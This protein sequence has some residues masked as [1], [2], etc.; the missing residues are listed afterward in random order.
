MR[1]WILV[2]SIIALLVAA[3]S[4]EAKPRVAFVAGNGTYK[5]VPPLP[6]AP[7]S[8]RAMASL[9]RE[10]GF[11][12]V[13]GIDLTRDRMSEKLLQFGEKADGAEIAVFY[14]SGHGIALGGHSYLVPTDAAIK[15]EM[16]IMLGDALDLELMLDQ[17][18][19]G[20]RARLVFLD[21]SRDNPFAGS[22]KGAPI[23]VGTAQIRATENTLT[24]FATAPGHVALDGPKGSVTPFTRALIANIAA[25][26]VEIQQAMTKVRAEVSA[27]TGGKQLPF[28]FTN[29]TAE[30][31]LKAK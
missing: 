23:Q 31:Y 7:L 28:V 26:G 27:E 24:A 29:L 11:D 8:A 1:A 2:V 6:N 17:T 20:A 3:N 25:P 14:Y 9:L 18:M 30:I 13:E 10:A 15:S 12:V 19:S 21:T 22:G 4:A 16:G 5:N